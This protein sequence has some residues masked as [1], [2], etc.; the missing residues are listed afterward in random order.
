VTRLEV[1]LAMAIVAACSPSAGA[2]GVPL[3]PAPVRVLIP[4][5]A[6]FDAILTGAYRSA[7]LGETN[8]DD[9]VAGAW[10]ITPVGAKL[11]AQ[12]GKLAGD[13]PW[14]WAEILKLKPR[15]LGLALLAP[16]SL[17]FV[18]VID[19]PAAPVVALPSGRTL[20]TANGTTYTVVARGAGDDTPGERRMG[21]AWA[22]S[23]TLLI[24]A[25]SESAL[26]RT[27]DEAAAGQVFAPKL[28]GVVA[29]ELD[30]DALRKDRYFRRDYLFGTPTDA[31]LIAVALRSEAGRLVEVREG[32]GDTRG[33][34]LAFET[35]DAAAAA[36]EPRGATFW[37]ALRA[38]LLEPRPDLLAR[39]LV[40]LRPLP[41]AYA[42]PAEDRY[43]VDLGKPL[44]RPGALWEEGDLALWRELASRHTLAGWGYR[45]GMD[46]TRVLVFDWPQG[47]MPD[48]ERA[49]RATLERRAG[50]LVLETVGVIREF[51]LG[52]G[53]PVFALTRVGDQV[54]LGPSAAALGDLPAAHRVPD[55]VGWA[56]V[57]LAGARAE[58]DRWAR[59]EGPHSPEASRPFS[60]RIL[61]LLGWMPATSSVSVERRRTAGGWTERVEFATR[62]VP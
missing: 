62:P 37:P 21:L 29:M 43:L 36:W 18:L 53:L 55:L 16:G 4:D 60:D 10:R 61:G 1:V 20:T 54:W 23:G 31:G 9:K 17:E 44:T 11:E 6:A 13:L 49:C 25:T 35:P 30:I 33:E 58:A 27:L 24:L 14:S 39:P 19:T 41:A 34:A 32:T 15:R 57:D 52:P 56:R 2:S 48:L 3:P 50:R 28:T 38:G 46:G 12:W 22:H 26:V 59:S 42:T 8:E 40:P 47:L 7:F 51:R 45:V 5:V